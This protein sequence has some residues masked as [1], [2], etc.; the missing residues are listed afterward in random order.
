[1]SQDWPGCGSLAEAVHIAVIHGIGLRVRVV[2]GWGLGG[3]GDT[4][5]S[6]SE[7]LR[8]VSFSPRPPMVAGRCV[9]RLKDTSKVVSLC[10]RRRK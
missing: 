3:E 7:A 5:R 9:S 6:L 10:E 4:C 2:W 1:M 8:V